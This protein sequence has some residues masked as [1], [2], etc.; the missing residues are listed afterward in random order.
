MQDEDAETIKDFLFNLYPRFKLIINKHNCLKLLIF[1]DKIDERGLIEACKAFAIKSAH[2]DPFVLLEHSARNG[3]EDVFR[4]SS[5]EVLKN[6]PFY[7]TQQ[8]YTEL[9]CRLRI[10]VSVANVLYMPRLR[11]IDVQ[12][13]YP[14]D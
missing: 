1:A 8:G 12:L 7:T 11:M 2:E 6:F 14:F 13:S 4:R 9:S 5:S 3:L 10:L